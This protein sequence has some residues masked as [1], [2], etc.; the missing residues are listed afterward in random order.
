MYIMIRRSRQNN[1]KKYKISVRNINT[2][3]LNSTINGSCIRNRIVVFC[4]GL[5][6]ILCIL[7]GPCRRSNLFDIRILESCF[8]HFLRSCSWTMSCRRTF[9]RHPF[10][11]LTRQ[12]LV[13]CKISCVKDV[14]FSKL[15]IQTLTTSYYFCTFAN[16]RTV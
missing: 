8:F 9:L 13:P 14:Y 12:I 11:I 10:P 2:E 16:K 3:F 15:K 4:N 7:K 6:P 1:K 5:Y